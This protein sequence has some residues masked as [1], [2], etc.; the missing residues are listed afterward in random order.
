[1]IP[2]VLGAGCL[3]ADPNVPLLTFNRFVHWGCMLARS[4]VDNLDQLACL[5]TNC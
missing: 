2:V 5:V 1:M 3:H 4:D